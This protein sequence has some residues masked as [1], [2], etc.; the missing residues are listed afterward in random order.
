MVSRVLQIALSPTTFVRRGSWPLRSGPHTPRR[1]PWCDGH[2]AADSV[3]LPSSWT[4]HQQNDKYT[5]IPQLD[6]GRT[7]MDWRICLDLG[8]WRL[9]PGFVS[10]FSVVSVPSDEWGQDVPPMRVHD[11]ACTTPR[12]RNLRVLCAMRATIRARRDLVGTLL[13]VASCVQL[14][15]IVIIA[16]LLTETALPVPN[17]LAI[18]FVGAALLMAVLL[19]VRGE[20]LQAARGERWALLGIGAAF[21]GMSALSYYMALRYGQTSAL[22]L[23]VY[24]Y[25][26]FVVFGSVI[27][28]QGLPSP[29]MAAAT[30]LGLS[31]VA[32]IVWAPGGLSVQP[33]GIVLA[34]VAALAYAAYLLGWD[35]LAGRTNSVTASLWTS[36]SAGVCLLVF[37]MVT[38]GVQVPDGQQ[39]V[40]LLAIS[41]L[42]VGAFYGLFRGIRLLGSVK[43][44]AI[45]TV[46]PLS[47]AGLA[48]VI[49]HDQP[50]LG[51]AFGAP[52]IVIAAVTAS[53]ATT[54]QRGPSERH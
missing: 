36:G 47:T 11:L 13:I 49:L 48:L 43:V 17:L 30:L 15:S 45:G 21:Y 23:I 26:I 12:G 35:R 1:K 16:K 14:G 50:T 10:R 46:E 2:V 8:G 7:P 34:V 31:G 24:S 41:V 52:L 33:P 3:G 40:M 9:C 39:A 19:S 54:R 18:R 20:P 4:E 27:L 42:T 5:V 22:A 37:S 28:G 29:L 38:G 32:L 25:P 6:Q 53:L 44:A 51:F